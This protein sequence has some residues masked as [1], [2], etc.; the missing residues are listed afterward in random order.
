MFK[1]ILTI[2]IF[3]VLAVFIQFIKSKVVAVYLG[4]AGV[5]IVGTID[6]FVQLAAF[7]SVFGFP[8]ASIKFLSK[9][10]SESED[11]FK[12]SC[13][14][15][16]K[17][18]LFLSAAGAFLIIAAILLKPNLLGAELE[19]Y[20]LF[21]MLGLLTLPT[22]SLTAL[23][24]NVFAASQK[25]KASSLLFLMTGAVSAVAAVAG[26]IYADIFG[27]YVGN[28]LAGVFVIAAVMIYFR[29]KLGLSFYDRQTNIIKEFKS[30][31]AIFSTALLL[32]LSAITASLS[33]L[34]ARYAVLAN[35]GETQAGLL[36]AAL[37]L[38]FAF[39]T[40]LYPAINIYL[41]PLVNRN[42][43]REIKI[44]QAIQFQ[45][46]LALMLSAAAMPILM[47]PKLMLTIMFSEKFAGVGE[48]VYL[49]VLSQFIVQLAGVYQSLLVGLDDVKSYT[50][51]TSATQIVSAG[52]CLLLVPHYGI[53]GAALGFLIG[54]SLN[55]AVC[56]I[57]LIVK[58]KFS[59]A[60]QIGFLLGYIFIVLFLTG[61]IC[62]QFA[63]W[64]IIIV[65]VK[66]AVLL[67]FGGSL[68]L[69]LNGEEKAS[70]NVL[71][72]KIFSEKS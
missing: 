20:K 8:A 17:S 42:A 71:R 53:R 40:A 31:P 28:L 70:L 46:K 50:F 34:T 7:V 60:P 47:F 61:L 37:V 55:F 1:I 56:L 27:L 30:N 59:V 39:G 64:D 14:G 48:T 4:P 13:A 63:E 11:A 58:Y 25:F 36:H 33:Y 26:V 51:I 23:F 52:M 2:G 65:S 3:Q 66:I 32:Y 6:Q 35:F 57:W 12:R 72:R 43:E 10:H 62:G 41:N 45:R 68:F 19:K 5:G 38:A 22:F 44:R 69:F 18:L 16:F 9:A 15:F 67:L 49:F 21:V 24:G 29:E 54:N